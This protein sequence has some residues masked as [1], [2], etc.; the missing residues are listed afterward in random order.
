MKL[1]KQDIDPRLEEW[2]NNYF[3]GEEEP[4]RTDLPYP[5]WKEQLMNQM[6]GLDT[7]DPITTAHDWD[8]DEARAAHWMQSDSCDCNM[9]NA[10]K[11][12]YL[13][14][15]MMEALA[16]DPNADLEEIYGELINEMAFG[17]GGQGRAK[18]WMKSTGRCGHCGGQAEMD[19]EGYWR[20]TF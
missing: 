5:Q 8:E 2:L 16:E 1:Q 3:Q 15:M 18:K 14:E 9:S 7:D 11:R 12:E 13:Q 4:P 10:D 17:A 6:Y 19:E 20:Q